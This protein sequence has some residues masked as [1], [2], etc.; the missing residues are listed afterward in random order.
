VLV[1][2]KRRARM[3]MKIYFVVSVL[4]MMSLACNNESTKP[5]PMAE[6]TSKQAFD[7]IVYFDSIYAPFK[8][9]ID[10]YFT[11]LNAWGHFNGVILFADKNHIIAHKALGYASFKPKEPLTLEHTF[12]LA[13]AS[14]PFTA[15]A[16]MQLV[17]QG[18]LS[19]SDSVEKFIQPFPYKGITIEDLLTHKSGLGQYTHFCDNPSY[20][21]SDKDSTIKNEDVITIINKVKPPVSKRKKLHLYSNTN[22]ILLAEIIKVVSGK[23]FEDYMDEEIFTPSNMFHSR[24][25]NR[26]NSE[27]LCTPTT[28]HNERKHPEDDIYL[29][30]CVGDKGIF[31][32]AKDL[33]NFH[34]ALLDGSVLSQ[35]YQDSAYKPRVD[36]QVNDQKYGYGWR[37]IEREEGDIVFHTGWWKGYKTYFIRIPSKQQL[38][39]V[40][41]NTVT[42]NLSIQEICS[43]LP[44]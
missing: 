37:I 11:K 41:S 12:Q 3:R 14:K 43:L 24:V 36:A 26:T 2:S 44:R 4:A 20:I 13:S 34:L 21:W 38:A 17:Q 32:N 6:L 22:Y 31:S 18:K 39:V 9:T 33:F 15:I 28:G 1:D 29:N 35:A 5:K 16:I 19:L 8:D 10:M 23:S 30:G 25:Y 27:E 42:T 40:L 7:S